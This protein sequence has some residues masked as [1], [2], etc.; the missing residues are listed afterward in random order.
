MK[1]AGL[2]TPQLKHELQF[3]SP[4]GD[5]EQRWLRRGEAFGEM[6]LAALTVLRCAGHHFTDSGRPTPDELVPASP[7]GT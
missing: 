2:W 3:L 6:R 1:E 7:L 4:E 5:E